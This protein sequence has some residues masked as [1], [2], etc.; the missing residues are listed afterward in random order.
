LRRVFTVGFYISN[1]RLNNRNNNTTQIGC[2]LTRTINATYIPPATLQSIRDPLLYA[3]SLCVFTFF[4]FYIS[5]LLT[6]SNPEN[7]TLIEY[8]NKCLVNLRVEYI[9]D[10]L[11]NIEIWASAAA[12]SLISLS[13][14]TWASLEGKPNRHIL[15][16]SIKKR[17]ILSTLAL[18]ST[19]SGVV[20]LI[21]T[22]SLLS[23]ILPITQ[24]RPPEPSGHLMSTWTITA[25]LWVAFYASCRLHTFIDGDHI[26]YAIELARVENTLETVLKLPEGEEIYNDVTNKET[27]SSSSATPCDI[28]LTSAVAI[29]VGMFYTAQYGINW[30]MIATLSEL[31]IAA[32]I[33]KSLTIPAIVGFQS[34]AKSRY[35]YSILSRILSS[36]L[37]LI[38]L[39]IFLLVIYYSK[40]VGVLGIHFLILGC[41]IISLASSTASWLSSRAFWV[42]EC[43]SIWKLP[44]FK[45]ALRRAI[46]GHV[47]QKNSLQEIIE[48]EKGN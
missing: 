31:P 20:A 48:R 36:T 10:Q 44:W 7:L 19:M 6:V 18:L 9:H 43:K 11:L 27:T 8:S 33:T 25:T 41:L 46:E 14:E 32:A 42:K 34:K 30:M 39:S 38:S 28:L 4:F 12:I 35:F 37:A 13:R 5:T 40:K 22:T 26:E 15:Q 1:T 24:E 47:K 45:H 2:N 21:G 29:G 16:E 23:K 17:T 3:L